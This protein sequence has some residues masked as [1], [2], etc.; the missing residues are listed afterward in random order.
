[1]R[2]A[3]IDLGTN[4]FHLI[5]ADL[6]AKNG[7]LIYKVNLPVKLGEGRINDNIMIE[8]AFERGLV[9]LEGFAA[10]IKEHQATVVKAT[11]T[12]AIRSAI[13][14][15]DFVK[16]AKDR[17]GIEIT[18]ISGDEEA[19]FIYKAVQATGLIRETSLV[20]DIGGGSTE[21]I[22]CTATKVLWKKSYNIGAARLMQAF[23]KS[24]PISD[25]EKSSIYHHVA[26]E[27]GGL[28]EQC[29]FYKPSRLIGSAGAFESFAVM[30]MI[31]RNLP[32]RDIRSGEID[33]M[34]YLQL[35]ERLIASTHEQRLHMEG[36]IPLRVD[37]I[38]IASLLV[39]FVL[40][41]TGIRQLSLSTNDLKWG[42][43]T[44]LRE[45]YNLDS[46]V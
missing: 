11:A 24:D 20:M 1:M 32:A 40:E 33:Y 25:E 31:Q 38:V 34:Q 5:I 29:D 16:A 10:T 35:T 14:G 44:S 2:A 4:T 8:A 12:S 6:E 3:V 21:F 7:E 22:I 43:L 18:V 39:N 13:N 41:N 28:L 45:G 19:A 42:V 17:T 23:F 27:V 46:S 9:A 37:M 30:L 15:T 26:N 36:L